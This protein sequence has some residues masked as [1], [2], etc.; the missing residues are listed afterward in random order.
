MISTEAKN[1]PTRSWQHD[2]LAELLDMMMNILSNRYENPE[3]LA[4]EMHQRATAIATVLSAKQPQIM[5][6]I[7]DAVGVHCLALEFAANEIA[8]ATR[9]PRD[10]IIPRLHYAGW[11]RYKTISASELG[12]VLDK[13]LNGLAVYRNP[14]IETAEHALEDELTA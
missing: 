6:Q 7:L 2:A 10:Q 4:G 3:D 13:A 5:P 9:E 12:N 14:S 8:M 1:F 11:E